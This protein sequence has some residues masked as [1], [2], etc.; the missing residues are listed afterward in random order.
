MVGLLLGLVVLQAR[1]QAPQ[2]SPKDSPKDMVRAAIQKELQDDSKHS[3]LLTWKERK[4]LGHETQVEHI[5]DTP[6]GVVSR[7]VLIDDKPLNPAQ[8]AEEDERVRKMLD[9]SQMRRM[10]KDRQADD[11]RTKAMLATIPDAFDFTYIDSNVA[12][13]GHKLAHLKFVARSGFNPPNRE[14]MVFSGM[15]GDMLLD[16]TAIRLAKIDGTLFKEVT[17][18]W[19]ILGKL[20]KGGHFLVEQSEV[21]PSHWD[22][23]RMILHFEGKALFFKTIHIEDNETSWDFQPVQPMS[24]QQAVDFL[25]Q[26][27]QPAQNARLGR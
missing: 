1:A 20:Y 14:A 23:T 3:P 16:E 12:P 10:K 9:P 19:G 5:V 6:A 22:T 11:E 24:V 21:T 26:S 13:N 25:R 18:G 8:R 4:Y 27:E 2:T 15:Q 17:F 7:V